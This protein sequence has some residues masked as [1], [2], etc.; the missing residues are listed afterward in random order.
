MD[1]GDERRIVE[2]APGLVRDRGLQFELCFHVRDGK[3]LL[4]RLL[5]IGVVLF[6]ERPLNISRPRLLAFD[7]IRVVRQHRP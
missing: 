5:H 4:A 7:T 3:T 6:R 1:T 2:R